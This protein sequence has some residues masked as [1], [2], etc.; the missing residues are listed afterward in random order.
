MGVRLLHNN[1]ME[2]EDLVKELKTEIE[3][4]EDKMKTFTDDMKNTYEVVMKIERSIRT[5]TED[6]EQKLSCKTLEINA[7]D[8]EIEKL[9]EKIDALKGNLDSVKSAKEDIE[10]NKK[11]LENKLSTKN[12]DI[13]AM[14]KKLANMKKKVDFKSSLEKSFESLQQQYQAKVDELEKLKKGG[15]LDYQEEIILQK[16]SFKEITNRR[17]Y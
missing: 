3:V 4:K 6:Y 11:A 2:L 10:S 17:G 8:R 5:R 13:D 15:V 12:S 7:K 1:R 9:N 16:P 14:N